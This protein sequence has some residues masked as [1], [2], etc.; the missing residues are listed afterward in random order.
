MWWYSLILTVRAHVQGVTGFIS[1]KKT[2]YWR[3]TS[4]SNLGIWFKKSLFIP[5]G[6]QN[7]L[8]TRIGLSLS[9]NACVDVQLYYIKSLMFGE[10]QLS[11]DWG[12]FVERFVVCVPGQLLVF[13]IHERQ[14]DLDSE[15]QAKVSPWFASPRL[16]RTSKNWT[17]LL[18]RG[19]SF[20]GTRWL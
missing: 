5:K 6:E 20:N 17:R 14:N 4:V 15:N 8:Y 1:L 7:A 16:S 18:Q 12:K 3:W 19:C 10:K 11:I 13:I 2:E 9:L